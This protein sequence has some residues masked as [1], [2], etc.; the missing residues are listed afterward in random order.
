L[1]KPAIRV[2]QTSR[3]A[4]RLN[5]RHSIDNV[6]TPKAAVARCPARRLLF[7]K[8]IKFGSAKDNIF[9]RRYWSAILAEE[10]ERIGKQ[11]SYGADNQQ[12]RFVFAFAEGRFRHGSA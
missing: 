2:A 3:S 12:R 8:Y 5:F 6:V 7:A 11:P 4:L 9:P 1:L 10:G